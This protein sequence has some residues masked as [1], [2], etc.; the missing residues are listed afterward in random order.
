M[1]RTLRYTVE[2]FTPAVDRV[3]PQRTALQAELAVVHQE[4]ARLTAAVAQGGDLHA[5]V[6]GV[7]TTIHTAASLRNYGRMTWGTCFR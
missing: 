2:A 1:G 5:L 6:E 7:A 3:V 4:L